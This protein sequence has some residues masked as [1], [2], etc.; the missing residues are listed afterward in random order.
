MSLFTR[1]ASKYNHVVGILPPK[2]VTSTKNNSTPNILIIIKNLNQPNNS[3]ELPFPN[4]ITCSISDNS[5]NIPLS[6][7][8]IDVNGNIFCLLSHIEKF[9]ALS[10]LKTLML[11]KIK[12][13]HYPVPI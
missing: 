10:T 11:I 13:S 4:Q 12:I 1:P 7:K 9:L 5:N 6:T 8:M 3:T 2:Q